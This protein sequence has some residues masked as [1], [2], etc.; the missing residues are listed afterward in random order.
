MNKKPILSADATFVDEVLGD[1]ELIAYVVPDYSAGRIRGLTD[2]EVEARAHRAFIEAI[3]MLREY[4][5]REDE[6]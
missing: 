6:A 3:S 1:L 5:M 2:A 4:V